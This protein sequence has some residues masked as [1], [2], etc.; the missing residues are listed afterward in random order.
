MKGG[1]QLAKNLGCKSLAWVART[2]EI[3]PDRLQDW[4]DDEPALF[5]GACLGAKA[6]QDGSEIAA[7]VASQNQGELI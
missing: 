5:R 1:S 6:I 2:L 3:T 4:F 7:L